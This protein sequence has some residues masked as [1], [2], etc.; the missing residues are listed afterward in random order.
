MPKVDEITDETDFTHTN[1]E[2][3]ASQYLVESKDG[4]NGS[5]V[6]K[7]SVQNQQ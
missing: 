7:H 6:T 1:K 4:L 2:Y 5:N 3:D